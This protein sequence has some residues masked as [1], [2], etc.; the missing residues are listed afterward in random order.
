MD[1]DIEETDVEILRQ[2]VKELKNR[3]NASEKQ[4]L[5]LQCLNECLCRVC[6]DA[7]L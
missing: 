2:Q 4:V 7:C 1:I 5:Y 3:L 6:A